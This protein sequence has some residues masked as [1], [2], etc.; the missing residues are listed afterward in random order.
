MNQKPLGKSHIGLVRDL[1]RYRASG[2]LWAME[3][4]GVVS[5]LNLDEVPREHVIDMIRR[6]DTIYVLHLH[7]LAER[8]RRTNHNPRRDLQAWLE[9]LQSREAVIVEM[10]TQRRSDKDLLP[11]IFDAVEVITKGARGRAIKIARTNGK[12]GGRPKA[13][14]SATR[15][16]AREIWFNPAY[17]GRDAMRRRLRPLGWSVA[18]CYR[19][20]GPR[21]G[22]T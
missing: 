7:L 17:T 21:Y 19:E 4:I 15:S 8:A 12:K 16:Q 1:P 20:F 6:G 18:R 14:V 11:M 10:H 13:D 5:I 9:A 3:T 2:Q 22:L